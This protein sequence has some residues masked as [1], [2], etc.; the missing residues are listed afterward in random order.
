MNHLNKNPDAHRRLAR[1]ARCVQVRG[2]SKT[3]QKGTEFKARQLWLDFQDAVGTA[4]EAISEVVEKSRT[5]FRKWVSN[6][7]CKTVDHVGDDQQLALFKP[8]K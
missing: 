5:W 8:A 4:L 7:V 1:E 3:Y 6:F 2:F